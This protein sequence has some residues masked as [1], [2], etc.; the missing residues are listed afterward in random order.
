MDTS[1][2]TSLLS[3][4]NAQQTPAVAPA[5]AA[6]VQQ[7]T[8]P[9]SNLQ[10]LL[11]G[12]GD[13]GSII[14]KMGMGMANMGPTGGD[15]YLAFA[16]GFGGTQKYTTEQQARAAQAAAEQQKLATEHQ[17]ATA[18]LNQDSSQFSQRM[19]QDQSQFDT[20]INQDKSQFDTTT[21]LQRAAEKRQ[22]VQ[23][24]MQQK[25]S[26][27]EIAR[28]A[29]NEG[30]S[31]DDILKI[32]RVAQAAAENIFDPKERKRVVDAE[33]DRLTKMF[34][35]QDL[36]GGPGIT[37]SKTVPNQGDVVDGYMFKGGDPANPANWKIQ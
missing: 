18:R 28:M 21:E 15:P 20:R 36:S 30:I 26:E 31:R 32:E 8:A 17:L 12:N 9:L 10:N 25:K 7:P 5:I 35:S 23:A 16:Q 34:K 11:A 3:G 22:Q 27:A 4:Y 24:D 19:N 29:R 33:R 6:P 13:I 14:Q 37:E 2:L 1:S